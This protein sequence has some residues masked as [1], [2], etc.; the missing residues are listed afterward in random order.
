MNPARI[1]IILVAGVAAIALALVVR[2]MA[3]KPNTG[4]VIQHAS[5]TLAPPMTRV[6]VA[7]MDLA[8]GDRLNADNMAWQTWPAATL[9]PAYV[10][11]G[12]LIA[13]QPTGAFGV[14]KE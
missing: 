7:K 10:T 14:I 4:T 2:N 6:L 12:S 8:V 11:D 13:P 1:A 5:A 3:S 9:N